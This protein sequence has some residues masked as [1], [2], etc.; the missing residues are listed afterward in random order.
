ME[1]LKPPLY[2]LLPAVMYKRSFSVLQLK[3]EV[4]DLFLDKWIHVLKCDWSVA[5]I[6]MKSTLL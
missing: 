4:L 2:C 1:I 3:L 5:I 6:G